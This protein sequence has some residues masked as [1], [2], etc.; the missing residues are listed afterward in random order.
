MQHR[1]VRADVGKDVEAVDACAVGH[2]SA[3]APGCICMLAMA[4]GGRINENSAQ[5]DPHRCRSF[6]YSRVLYAFFSQLVE[7]ILR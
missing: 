3:T 7:C 5:L 6:V 2:A 1:C 4:I